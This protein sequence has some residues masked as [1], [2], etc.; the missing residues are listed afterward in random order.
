ME[1]VLNLDHKNIKSFDFYNISNIPVFMTDV[2][3]A[4]LLFCWS[5]MFSAYSD[6]YVGTQTQDKMQKT[7]VTWKD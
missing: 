3:A 7:I 2:T 4:M 5:D 6:C 1:T